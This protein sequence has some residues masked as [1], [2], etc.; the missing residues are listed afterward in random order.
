LRTPVR[1]WDLPKGVKLVEYV[2]KTGG[3]YTIRTYKFTGLDM[4]RAMSRDDLEVFVGG[5]LA[6]LTP[7]IA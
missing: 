1:E 6:A 4:R 7:R 2:T 3:G 5:I